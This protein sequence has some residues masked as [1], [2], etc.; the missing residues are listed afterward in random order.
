MAE[1]SLVIFTVLSQMAAGAF[2]TLV[3][4]DRLSGDIKEAAGTFA[5]QGIVAVMGLGLLASLGHLGHPLEAFRAS[6][7]FT[8]SWLS[9]EVVLF[10]L[11][12]LLTVI[13]TWQWRSGRARRFAGIA[14]SVTALLAVP[15]SG[16]VYVVA[17]IPAWNNAGPLFFFLLT[18]GTLGPLYT[19]LLLSRKQYSVNKGLFQWV[20]AVLACSCL[21]FALYLSLLLGAGDVAALTGR[22]TLAGLSFWLRLLLGW[23]APLGVLGYS[24]IRQ[25]WH[26]PGYVALLFVL[27][28]IGEIVGR[29][30]F[31]GSAVPLTMFGL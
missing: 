4:M 23:L 16:M 30:L 21:S 15:T 5:A 18:A 10:G 14:G 28:L 1:W 25:Q 31:Y 12:F 22:N 29:G 27:V 19:A 9:R 3:L 20:F 13:Y 7:H 17:A 24:F 26:A 8:A 6:A 11:F 2:V